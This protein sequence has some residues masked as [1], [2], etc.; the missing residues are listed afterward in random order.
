M[1]N[2]KR[3]DPSASTSSL[4]PPTDGLTDLAR[5]IQERQLKRKAASSLPLPVDSTPTPTPAPS[6]QAKEV[7]EWQPAAGESPS[8][9][10]KREKKE[11]RARIL[12]E[13]IPEWKP[14]AG[15]SPAERE[16]REKREK[17]AG[18]MGGVTFDTGFAP[19]TGS[20]YVP[21]PSDYA[22]PDQSAQFEGA[23]GTNYDNST[24]STGASSIHPSRMAAAPILG[25]EKKEKDPNKEKTTAKKL[26]LKRKRERSK[27]KKAGEPALPGKRAKKIKRAEG[28]AEGVGE[29]DGD[30]D[31]DESSVDSDDEREKIEAVE[32]KKNDILKKKEERKI[33][34]D[35]KKVE[36]R[37]VKAEGGVPL[38][39]VPRIVSA[40][41]T[42]TPIIATPVAMDIDATPAEPTAEE[43][44]L[45][46]IEAAR[47]SRK[48]A[49]R[50]KRTARRL[51][52]PEP[53][54]STL[55]PTAHDEIIRSPTPEIGMESIPQ[56]EPAPLLRLP[57]ATRPAPPSAKTLSALK[58]HESV[59]DKMVIDPELKVA[60]GE[61]GVVLS[62]RAIKR[63][64]EM[65]I[66]D[67][68]AGQSLRLRYSTSYL[69]NSFSSN[70]RFAD[71]ASS[72][73]T[74]STLYSVLAAAGRLCLGADW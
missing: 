50:E 53:E 27:G 64:G 55:I 4:P 40:K 56:A 48:L 67:A 7:G 52:T 37:R 22:L 49:K 18:K 60:F 1:S 42:P 14:A 2:I 15:E 41:P 24:G 43:L 28:G 54:L 9:R 12:A 51:P 30:G 68:F 57:G 63:L 5:K 29:G 44:E 71:I 13:V 17:R 31:S 62:G 20:M 3:F 33:K 74:D 66:T 8:E 73:S 36:A 58:V 25:K 69:S 23:Y 59:R 35:E 11:K 34:R 21:P 6:A 65:G 38:A 19:P 70:C 46:V 39:V 61:N 10:E 72:W 26:Y 16:K 47:A 32:K 45:A